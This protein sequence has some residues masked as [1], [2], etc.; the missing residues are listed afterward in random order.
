MLSI[1][2]KL[3]YRGLYSALGL[4]IYSEAGMKLFQDLLRP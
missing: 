2:E 3:D 4:N 1:L